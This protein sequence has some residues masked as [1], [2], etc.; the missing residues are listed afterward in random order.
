MNRA[1]IGIGTAL[2]FGV[3]AYLTLLL[4]S[5]IS[6]ISGSGLL[7]FIVGIPGTIFMLPTI[8][9]T[10]LI[11]VLPMYKIFPQGGASG[12]FGSLLIF[13]FIIWSVL[14]GL[15]AWFRKWPF[16]KIN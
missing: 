14:F 13:A 6:G 12:V 3:I 10:F 1:F 2:I 8:P 11:D 5:Y 16:Q 15:L 7:G 4:G 9:F